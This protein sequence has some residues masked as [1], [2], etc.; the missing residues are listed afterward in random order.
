[1]GLSP[2]D[3]LKPFELEHA[4][5]I[6]A[7]VSGGSDSLALLFLLKDYLA[8]LKSPPSITVVT[9]D[10][11][12]RAESA[13]EAADVGKL[14]KAHGL[15]HRTLTWDDAKPK[16]GIAAAARS[17]RY[18]LL[19]QAAHEAGADVIATGHT[20][21]DQI[22]TF[23]MRKERSSHSEARGLAAMAS[24]SR[25]E[26][27]VELI[28]PLLHLSRAVL[29]DMLCQRGVVWIDDPSNVNTRYERP[30][31][32]AT[33]AALADP[34]MVL[35][36]IAVARAARQ[37]D[38]AI[39][40]AALANAHCLQMDPFGTIG[41]D[42]DVYAALPENIRRL[43]SGLL[44]SLAGGRRFLPGDAERSR[45]E[46][47]LSGHEKVDRLTIFGALI[48]LGKNGQPHC[49]RR[50]RRNLPV[51]R[52]DPG[53]QIIWDGRFRFHN[54]GTASLKVAA[55]DRQ[56]LGDFVKGAGLEVDSALREALLV[57]PAIYEDGKLSQLPILDGQKLPAG[58]SI[59]KHFALFDH[60][61]PGYDF[62]LA[63]AFEQR[64]GR[65]CPNFYK[66]V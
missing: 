58:I 21:D 35:E 6:V 11:G 4:K 41:V 17:A 57:L 8:T 50:E 62:A 10:H 38:N 34:A 12:L 60:V 5:G 22:E 15:S 2:V 45:I 52:L 40:I 54:D 20:S 61:L 64:F 24:R 59:E 16:T 55:P 27:S 46:K 53:Q 42:T 9:I 51:M 32:R 19:V 39:L 43:L 29:R 14:C 28:R 44:A 26:N 47:L 13:K 36:K 25:L 30:R 31:V 7:A 56:E 65:Q 49:F 63:K 3:I 66:P 18:R 23:L 1:M 48:E 37:R 33:T